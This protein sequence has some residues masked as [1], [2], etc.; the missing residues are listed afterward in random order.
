MV[1]KFR[2]FLES[3]PDAVVIADARG[4]ILIANEETES[5]FGFGGADLV[6]KPVEALVP[7]WRATGTQSQLSGLR[8]DGTA[9]AIEISVDPLDT[10]D[11]PLVSVTMRDITDRLM[12]EA[13]FEPLYRDAR[14]ANRLQDEL[15]AAV[16][17]DSED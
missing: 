12:F 13:S 4:V 1:A 16:S 3:A 8:R 9:V 15:L 17:R 10:D 5:L 7:L 6:G 14:E 2:G 11:G